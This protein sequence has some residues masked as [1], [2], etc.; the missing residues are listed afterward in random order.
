[1]TFNI[2]DVQRRFDRAAAHFDSADFVHDVTRRGLFER[3]LP[4][5]VEAG[6]VLDLGCATGAACR[7]LQK[8]F[9]G[10]HIVS[11]DLS[12]RMLSLA[13]QNR[14]W[15]SRVSYVQADAASLPFQENGFDVVF[16]NLLLPWA[17][18]LGVALTEVSRVLRPGGV[19]VFSTL[20]PDSLLELD[21]AWSDRDPHAHVHRFPDMHDI[22]DALVQAG[23][24]DPVLDVDRLALRYTDHRKLF[25]DLTNVGAR[26]ARRDRSPAL[27]GKRRFREMVS[28]LTEP[29]GDGSVALDLELVYGHCWGGEVKQVASDFRIDAAGI[30]RR[31][32]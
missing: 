7:P 5:V 29:T 18:D 21:R 11:L 15:F 20:G 2:R 28:A 16:A 25:T 9:R 12:H 31:R 22:G 19:F 24:R 23:L 27:T 1:M 8:R 14:R 30:P 4:L 32:G 26:N 3:L 10:A 6:T 13:T 17:N